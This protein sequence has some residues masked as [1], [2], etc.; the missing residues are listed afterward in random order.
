MILNDREK[1]PIRERAYQAEMLRASLQQNIIVSGNPDGHR[2]WENSHQVDVLRSHLPYSRPRSFTGKDQV[3]HWGEKAVWDA[4]LFGVRVA[5]STYQVLLDALTHGFTRIDQFSLLVFDEA[6]HCTGNSPAN[7]IMKNF[8]HPY[9]ET[10][11]NI[12]PRILGLSASPAHSDVS[13]LEKLESDLDS[14]CMG[15]NRYYQQL[16]DSTNRPEVCIYRFL[17]DDGLRI[18]AEPR[19]LSWLRGIIDHEEKYHHQSRTAQLRQLVQTSEA[20]YH[21]LGSWAATEYMSTSI[22]H[23]KEHQR[24]HAETEWCTNAVKDFTMKTLCELGPLEQHPKSPTKPADLSPKCR[25]LLETLSRL[26]NRDFRGLIFVVRRAAVMILKS[27]IENHPDTKDNFRCGAFVGMSKMQG[28]TDLGK[29]HD[30]ICGQEETLTKFRMKDLDLII[31]TNA[32][33]EGIDIPACNTIISFDRPLSL[34]SFVQRRGRARQKQSTFIIFANNKQEEEELRKLREL[35]DKLVQTYRD[36]TRAVPDPPCEA[37]SYLS[38]EVK[39]TGARLGMLDAVS[40]LNTFCAKLLRQPYVINRP[41]YHYQESPDGR[42]R[43]T[44]L[45]PSAL[46]PSLQEIEG[47]CW[48]SSRKH[49]KADTALQAYK[50]LRAAGLVNDHLLPTKPSDLIK[51]ALLSCKA[52]HLLPEPFNPWAEAAAQWNTSGG[53]LYA[54]R[55][56]IQIPGRNSLELMMIIPL[57]IHKQIRFPLFLHDETT[58]IVRLWPG[59]LVA[60]DH[61]N[62]LLYRRVTHLIL[63][64]VHGYLLQTQDRR[65]FVALFVPDAAPAA[66]QLFLETCSGRLPL[67]EALK[68]EK[69]TRAP[70]LLRSPTWPSCPWIINPWHLELPCSL[71]RLRAHIYPLPRRRNFLSRCPPGGLKPGNPATDH[72]GRKTFSKGQELTIDRL[73]LPWALAALYIPSITHEIG[74]CMVAER[75]REQVLLGMAFRRMGLLSLAIRPTCSERPDRFRSLAFVGATFLKFITSEQLFLHHPTWHQG[76]LSK[77]KETVVSDQ[78]LAQAARMCKLGEFLITRRFSGRKWKPAWISSFLSLPGSMEPRK[79]SARTLAEMVRAIVGAA[80]MDGGSKQAATCAATLVPA[81]KTWYAAALSDGSFEQTRPSPVIS[82]FSTLGEMEQLL[83]YKFTDRSLLVEALT[84]P[85]HYASGMLRTAAYGRLSFLGDAVLELVVTQ[86][87]LHA[88]NRTL[89]VD[90]L[91]S[92]RTA[93]TNNLFLVFLCLMFHMEVETHVG[94]ATQPTLSRTEE[95][96]DEVYLWTCLRSHSIELTT[97]LAK[98]RSTSRRNCWRTQLAFLRKTQYPWV[99]LAAMGGHSVLGDIVKSVLGAVFLDSQANLRDCR[100]LADRMGILPR[101]KQFLRDSVVTDH[102]KILL[103]KLHPGTKIFYQGYTIPAPDKPFCCAV[104]V[105]DEKLVDIQG[106]PNRNVAMVSASQVVAQLL[107]KRLKTR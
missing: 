52:F 63:Q 65:D 78:G 29:W 23:F 1:R 103:Q 38:L 48:W 5:V 37:D 68:S 41:L 46:H 32:L 36:G 58:I 39:D 85:S 33:E 6:H 77:L 61:Q 94:D 14:R 42:V 9:K 19:L 69:H 24:S 67:D 17:D 57:Q 73:P 45:L 93:V 79:I 84:H 31:T 90:R 83:G 106:C 82:C 92:L 4:A 22:R 16:L 62:T 2:D 75:L 100:H 18:S 40:H 91:Q 35:E 8:Y 105:D 7:R 54:H 28:L 81:I 101:V 102:P 80:Y 13:S 66:M 11:P 56:E 60:T 55:L 15:P 10:I 12:L 89:D 44:V 30:N 72:K 71:Q 87:L 34:R 99:E 70:G 27:L 95:T 21:E 20:L 51:P 47:S 26:V 43:A 96:L 86:T 50:A 104:W 74:I 97:A 49:A 25:G 107:Q 98:F 53:S 88:P 76:L 59:S 64:S 3:D